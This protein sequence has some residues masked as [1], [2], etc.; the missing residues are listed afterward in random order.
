ML[1]SEDSIAVASRSFSSNTFL[2]AAL[3]DKFPNSVFNETG[4]T[5]AGESLVKF[6]QGHVAAITALEI[7]DR[8]LLEKL[9]KLK[10]LSKYGVGLDMVDLEALHDFGVLLGWAPGVNRRSVSELV[11]STAISLL[12]KVPSAERD[13]RKGIWKQHR[14]RQLTGRTVGVVGCGSIGKDVVTLL[15]PFSCNIIAFDKIDYEDFFRENGV[16]L[17]DLHTLLSQ[18]DVVTVHLPLDDSTR[19][20]LNE[21]N[22]SYL[23]ESA[24]FINYSRGGIVDEHCLHRMMSSSRIGAIA[25]DVYVSEP[26]INHELFEFDNAIFTPHIGGSTEEAVLAMGL[27]A[28]EG[29][30]GAKDPL[31]FKE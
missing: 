3:L 4:L 12:H 7:V 15:K 16:V 30:L 27:A 21:D 11:V 17:A 26:V 19:N 24:I 13:L 9:P 20:I 18:S 22:L 31:S 28:I 8:R 6:L 10:V 5:L 29:L 1:N 2:R 25:L 23:K 14:G